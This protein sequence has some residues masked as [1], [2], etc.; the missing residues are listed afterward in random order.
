MK[1]WNRAIILAVVVFVMAATA[2]LAM[3]PNVRKAG[4]TT[5][6]PVPVVDGNQSEWQTTPLTST[7]PDWFAYMCTGSG[8]GGINCASDKI[9][10]DLFL[11]YDC[12]HNVLIGLALSDRG[13]TY[14]P[15]SA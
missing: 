1:S 14:A 13:F 12:G 3:A 2:A 7:N 9:H 11:R 6:V 8:G 5:G 15:G 10:G 4:G